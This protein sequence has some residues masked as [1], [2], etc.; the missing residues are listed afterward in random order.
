MKI[1]GLNTLVKFWLCQSEVM[2][3]I[4]MFCAVSQSDVMFAHFAARRNFTHTVNITA[5]GNITCPQGQ[6]SLKKALLSQC[7]FLAPLLG[8]EPR[9]PCINTTCRA[10]RTSLTCL[11]YE[12][13]LQSKPP[14]LA[15]STHQGALPLTRRG[16]WLKLKERSQKK[17][18]AYAVLSFGSPSWT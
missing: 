18:T 7:F 6:T 1:K 9:T 11:S 17:S 8:L 15:V 2:L 13:H 10:S 14:K 16:H 4:V 3:R 12:S 5:E